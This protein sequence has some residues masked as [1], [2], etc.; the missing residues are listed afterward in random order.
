MNARQHRRR[1][2]PV[3]RALTTR[4]A[5][6][7]TAMVLLGS[8]A[9]AQSSTP[10]APRDRDAWAET[11]EADALEHFDSTNWSEICSSGVGWA[12]EVTEVSAARRGDLVLRIDHADQTFPELPASQAVH[13]VMAALQ[14]HHPSLQWVI[15][16]DPDHTI[17][18]RQSRTD[19]PEK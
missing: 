17:L 1:R 14:P 5:V 11:M 7:G 6:A 10:T 8:C 12:C 16:T 18:A 19:R 13:E 3:A 4:L 2:S 15:A 9:P